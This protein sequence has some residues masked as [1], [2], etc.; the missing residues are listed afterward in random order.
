MNTELMER[1]SPFKMPDEVTVGGV[2]YKDPIEIRPTGWFE[3]PPGVTELLRL[4]G[5]KVQMNPLNRTFLLY[6]DCDGKKVIQS[7]KI[8]DSIKDWQDAIRQL[9]EARDNVEPARKDTSA[10]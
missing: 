10:V 9:Y 8:G 1:T 6:L 5:V 3:T 4:A 2:V 7:F